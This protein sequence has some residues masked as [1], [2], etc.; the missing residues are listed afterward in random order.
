MSIGNDKS[1]ADRV[2]AALIDDLLSCCRISPIEKTIANEMVSKCKQPLKETVPCKNKADT[3]KLY[4]LRSDIVVI[5]EC[6]LM[7]KIF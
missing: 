7:D 1:E 3:Q 4:G 5:D 2:F 6:M